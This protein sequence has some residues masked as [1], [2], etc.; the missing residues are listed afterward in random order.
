MVNPTL[1]V[2]L[3]QL[4]AFEPDVLTEFLALPREIGVLRISNRGGRAGS[5][6]L[7]KAGEPLW[8]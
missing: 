6:S 2:D 7:I 4:L 8:S 5:L 3:G 1:D